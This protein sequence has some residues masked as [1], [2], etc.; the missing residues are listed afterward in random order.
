V[1]GAVPPTVLLKVVEASPHLK[2]EAHAPQYKPAVLETG[3]TIS[4][5]PFVIAGDV[6]VVDTIQ[7]K[8]MKRAS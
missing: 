4:V 1:S 6:V 8:F 7:G 5:P 2:G 3:A